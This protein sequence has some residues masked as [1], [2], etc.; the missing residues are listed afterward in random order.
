MGLALEEIEFAGGGVGGDLAVPVVFVAG[1]EPEAEFRAFDGGE[2][3]DGFLDF[4]DG[5]HEE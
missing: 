3:G 1:F 4:G 5:A 2:A